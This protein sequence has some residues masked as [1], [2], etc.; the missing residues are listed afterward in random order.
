[1]GKPRG[2][3]CTAMEPCEVLYFST[4]QLNL[5]EDGAVSLAKSVVEH[6]VVGE[7]REMAFFDGV[8]WLL[9]A[10]PKNTV[11]ESRVSVNEL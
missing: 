6:F 11:S 9:L 7:M 1:M 2:H 5:V 4:A 3:T 10:P 8:P